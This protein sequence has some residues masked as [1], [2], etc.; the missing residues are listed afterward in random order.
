M[1]VDFFICHSWP[2]ITNLHLFLSFFSSI[3]WLFHTY[4]GFYLFFRDLVVV[5]VRRVID[6]ILVQHVVLC[7]STTFVC[8]CHGATFICG[9]LIQTIKVYPINDKILNQW[10][11]NDFDSIFLSIYC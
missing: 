4:L 6:V 5:L 10:S 9:R 11:S 1:R 2:E 8:R 7:I 3:K